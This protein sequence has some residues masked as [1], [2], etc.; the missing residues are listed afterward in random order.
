M[1]GMAGFEPATTCTPSRCATR[2]RHIPR[3]RGS[4]SF[5]IIPLQQSQYFPQLLP[6]LAEHGATPIVDG[7]RGLAFGGGCWYAP[8]E[9]GLQP[10]L[11][12]RNRESFFVEELFD[13]KHGL[14]VPA[15][16]DPLP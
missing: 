2:L 3:R 12:P 13:P 4:N 10:F 1:V 16:I 9:L 7:R 5:C 8:G 11:G 14:D 15:P 6:D